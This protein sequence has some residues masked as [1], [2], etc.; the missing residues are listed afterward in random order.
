VLYNAAVKCY[1]YIAS[2]TD[3]LNISMEH[4]CNDNEKGEP[5]Y[6]EQN[7]KIKCWIDKQHMVMH[8][9][10]YQY[11]ETALKIDFGP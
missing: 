10:S 8:C 7:W 5:K 2:V 4:W 3:K 9:R 6:L 1:N 11:P